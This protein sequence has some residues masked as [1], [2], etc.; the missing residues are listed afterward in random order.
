MLNMV[1]SVVS[2][3]LILTVLLV[4]YIRAKRTVVEVIEE[5]YPNIESVIEHVKVEMV[6][7]LQED[8]TLGLSD[9]D[10]NLRYARQAK[11][12]N[13]LRQCV[14]GDE[15]AKSL[16][17][18]LIRKWVVDHLS[19]AKL[20]EMLGLSEGHEPSDHMKF[21]MLMYKYKSE[22][23]KGCGNLALSTWVKDCRGDKPQLIKGTVRDYAF[24]ITVEKL[25]ESFREKIT[26]FNIEEKRDI[27]SLLVYQ[28][29]K[30]FGIVDTVRE[31]DINGFNLGT[32]GSIMQNVRNQ[33]EGV[34]RATKSLWLFFE[35]K[36][37]H[38]QFMDFG[39]EE[40]IQ[41]IVQLLV[42]YNSPGPLTAAKGF[43]VNTMIDKSRILALRPPASE[44]WATFVRK[45][46]LS[47][48]TTTSLIKKEYT[49]N[50]EIPIEYIRYSM[51]GLVTCAV[52]GRQGSGK[53]T[54]MS[55]MVEHIDPMYNI[56]VLEMAPEL[57][58]REMYPNH[59]NILS[60]Q[61][62]NTVPAKDL[63]DALK[64]S[65]AAVSMV[66][67]VAT[68]DIAG[69]MIQMGMTAS[70]FTI[71][72]HHANTARDLV[73][74]LRNSLAAANGFSNMQTAEKQVLQVVR[75]DVHLDSTAKGLRYIERITEIIPLDE[76]V[77]YPEIDEN[78]LELSR[79]KI[80]REKAIR[81]TD[82]LSFITQDLIVYDLAT[83]TYNAVNR[84]SVDL[85][86]DMRKRMEE[87]TRNEFDVFIYKYWGK[88]KNT[89]E[90]DE[91]YQALVEIVGSTDEDKIQQYVEDEWQK[92]QMLMAE[93]REEMLKERKEAVKIKRINPE[94]I[95][96]E[97]GDIITYLDIISEWKVGD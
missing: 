94:V 24:F 11:I 89:E 25:H 84:P 73:Y 29:Y 52:T 14:Y 31:M 80:E 19:E 87:E 33:K 5:D 78:N 9:A 50:A 48:V 28:R 92:T 27:F 64:K 21:E 69:R 37:I 77:P 42:R 39:S 10:F 59:K 74:T 7:Y 35:G 8:Y 4:L 49:V 20:D 12:D 2:L 26:G 6:S 90:V 34:L 68:D 93:K 17:V 38:L 76:N 61:E 75:Q 45:F 32:S 46:N 96:E 81:Q 44:F 82:R 30:G 16:V 85:E 57:Y 62:T 71:F 55:A 66:G 88:R 54:L 1:L 53:T 91:V 43:L 63:Q 13:A 47:D 41:R 51:R 86:H 72:S 15:K 18:G 56:R 70:L 79:L 58:L 22:M 36:Y 95:E 67:E 60:V 97:L 23:P 83:N 40:E 3:I 65:D